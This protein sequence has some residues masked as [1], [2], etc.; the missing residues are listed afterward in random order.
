MLL[1]WC[2]LPVTCCLLFR[3]NASSCLLFVRWFVE[4]GIT[5]NSVVFKMF[6]MFGFACDFRFMCW[7]FI[8]L[9]LELWVCCLLFGLWWCVV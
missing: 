5:I 9:R 3:L 2:Y 1:V 7:V 8:T 6:D 4:C